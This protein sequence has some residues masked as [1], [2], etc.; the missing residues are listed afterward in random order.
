M[1]CSSDNKSFAFKK[2]ELFLLSLNPIFYFKERRVSTLQKLG[3]YLISMMKF[4]YYTESYDSH[5]SLNFST[6]DNKKQTE[7]GDI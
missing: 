5:K 4:C 2:K 3:K 6:S 7:C 1:V